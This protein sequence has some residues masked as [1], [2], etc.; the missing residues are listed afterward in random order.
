MSVSRIYVSDK[1]TTTT[2]TTSTIFSYLQSIAILILFIMMGAISYNNDL[3]NN[4]YFFNPFFALSVALALIIVYNEML[5]YVMDAK[6]ANKTATNTFI[7]YGSII[8]LIL[9]SIIVV[10]INTENVALLPALAFLFSNIT[11]NLFFDNGTSL[12]LG[13]NLAMCAL[14][15]GSLVF[16]YWFDWY[17]IGA[18]SGLI[19]LG[20][21]LTGLYEKPKV[22]QKDATLSRSIAA[23]G[24]ITVIAFITNMFLSETVFDLIPYKAV[25]ATAAAASG[26]GTN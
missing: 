23:V 2:T 10:G 17:M 11:N 13:L 9:T 26:N 15:I 20:Y 4:A 8:V 6:G 7:L 14:V 1:D 12:T 16:S 24:V 18:L 22:T 3:T 19:M 5:S 21:T 25:F